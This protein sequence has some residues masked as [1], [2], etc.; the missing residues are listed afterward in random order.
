[1]YQN[2]LFDLDDTLLDFQA[3]QQAGITRIL[4]SQGVQDV[5]RGLAAYERINHQVWQQIERGADRQPL[6][7]QRFNDLFAQFGKKVD[8]LALQ[9]WYAEMEASNYRTVSGATELLQ[10][11]QG[12]GIKIFAAS[13]G[14]TGMQRQRLK[15]A[16]LLQYFDGVFVSEEIG[17]AKPDPRFFKR[18]MTA[19]SQMTRQNTIMVG[20]SWRSDVKGAQNVGLNC[21]WLTKKDLNQS[22]E[23]NQSQ[24]KTARNLKEVAQLIL[25]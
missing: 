3:G 5:E 9:R 1:M 24:I 17:V 7:D 13:N 23:L 15:G 20:D 21:I 2:V 18:I 4:R 19:E 8:G 16:E 22:N 11:L 10:K 12:C 25:E 6:F 14:E